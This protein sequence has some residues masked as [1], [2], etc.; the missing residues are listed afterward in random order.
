MTDELVLAVDGR[1]AG[2]VFLG[3]HSWPSGPLAW[4]MGF[5][6]AWWLCFKIKHSKRTSGFCI[7]FYD[8]SSRSCNLIFTV[9]TILPRFKGRKETLPLIGKKCQSHKNMWVGRYYF[10]LFFFSK[11]HPITRKK[12]CYKPATS[13]WPS[14]QA[15]ELTDD[16][17]DPG[18]TWEVLLHDYFT[19]LW[20]FPSEEKPPHS[21]PKGTTTADS[22]QLS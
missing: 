8:L 17:A 4:A 18:R 5:F 3:P 2:N 13:M 20:N 7:A 14:M 16:P 15:T 19:V 9:V 1:P 22:S 11:I 21:N 10:I 12:V 6:T